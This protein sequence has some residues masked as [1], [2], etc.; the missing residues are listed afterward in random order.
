MNELPDCIKYAL[1][2]TVYHKT[3]PETPGIVT[4]IC[5]YSGGYMYEVTWGPTQSSKCYEFELTAQ[6]GFVIVE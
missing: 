4:G 2:A 5:F 3:Q 6:K 1:E